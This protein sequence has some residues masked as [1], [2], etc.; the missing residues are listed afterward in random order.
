MFHM[1]QH[2]VHLCHFLDLERTGCE[3]KLTEQTTWIETSRIQS[4]QLIQSKLRQVTLTLP[5]FTLEEAES[6]WILF[7][8]SSGTSKQSAKTSMYF[9]LSKDVESSSPPNNLSAS[10]ELEFSLF[11]FPCQ[12]EGLSK[13]NLINVN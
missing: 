4:I 9:F 11:F 10:P 5:A 3:G 6:S 7:T 1:I 13:M 2:Y 12:I 8:P